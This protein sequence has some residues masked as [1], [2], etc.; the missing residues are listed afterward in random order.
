MNIKKESY[1]IKV[2]T[3]IIVFITVQIISAGLSVAISSISFG[4]WGGLWII[5]T[6]LFKEYDVLN[7]FIKDNLLLNALIVLFII[8][9]FISRTFSLIPEGAYTGMKRMLLFLVFWGTITTIRNKQKFFYILSFVLFSYS[10]ISLI[11]ITRLLYDYR[12][13][14][15]TTDA[16]EMRISYF[17]YPITNGEIKM[18]IL[19]TVTPLIFYKNKF[20]FR[21]SILLS[22]VIPILISMILTQSRNVILAVLISFMFYS[23]LK[24]KKIFFTAV[25]ALPLIYLILPNNFQ[26]RIK[27]TFDYKHPSNYSRLMMWETGLKIFAD[28][29]VIGVG[30]NEITKI[31]TKYKKPEYHGEGSHLHSNFIM[32]LAT[33]GIIGFIIYAGFFSLLLYKQILILK[34]EH[35]I[36]YQL[37]ITGSILSMISFHI[38]GIFEWSFGDWEVLTVLLFTASIPFIIK[39]FDN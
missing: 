19:L 10:V 22:A 21:R 11:E 36:T 5:K 2:D 9:E 4:I 23:L 16:G 18:L 8:S 20:P 25:F 35:E 15:F 39:N 24:N 1:L 30:D 37:I 32:I 29:P 3:L 26:D 7:K 6:F 38:S 12:S 27:S 28:Y 31:Y 34:K 33:N 13:N 14:I 17:G